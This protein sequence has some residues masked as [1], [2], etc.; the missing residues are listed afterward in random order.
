MTRLLASLLLVALA[1]PAVAG[2][3]RH[4][5]IYL[6]TT[7]TGVGGTNHMPSPAPGV[8]A[9]VYVCFDQFGQGGGMFGASWAFEEIPGP[10]YFWTT[11]LYEAV[12]G[13]TIGDPG[14][15]PGCSMVVGP[16]P[17]YPGAS[18]IIVLARVRYE[19]PDGRRQGGTITIV[20]SGFPEGGAVMDANNDL[21]TWC[22]HSVGYNGLSGNFAWDDSAV[23]DGNCSTAPVEATSWGSIK[24]LY[25]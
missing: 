13:L 6:C 15:P 3:N 19:T 22:V 4:V 12:G 9:S 2:Q 25:R 1:I 7:S 5:G 8:L 23:P 21:D 16:S 10:D 11:N 20:P 24:A 14:I 17:V 18:G